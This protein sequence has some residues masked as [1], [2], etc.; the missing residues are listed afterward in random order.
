MDKKE[1]FKTV[2]IGIV[3]MGVNNVVQNVSDD[4]APED[5][6][7]LTKAITWIGGAAISYIIVSKVCDFMEPKIEAAVEYIGKQVVR[8]KDELK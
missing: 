6:K 8:V 7:G 1:I 3:G 5:S 4:A 2:A